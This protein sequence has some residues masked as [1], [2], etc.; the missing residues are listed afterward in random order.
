MSALSSI[1]AQDWQERP[2][3]SSNGDKQGGS[4]EGLHEP[5]RHD[6]RL[7]GQQGQEQQQPHHNHISQQET[8]AAAEEGLRRNQQAVAQNNASSQAGI[9]PTINTTLTHAHPPLPHRSPKHAA[10]SAALHLHLQT[11]VDSL[12]PRGFARL[13]GTPTI[14]ET[15][16]S[17][18]PSLHPSLTS[19]LPIPGA[20]SSI[21]STLSTFSMTSSLSPGSALP[22][23]YLAAMGDLTPLPSPFVGAVPDSPGG[24][25]CVGQPGSPNRSRQSSLLADG[26]SSTGGQPSSLSTSPA[27]PTGKRKKG[28]GSLFHDAA[29]ANATAVQE[30]TQQ[31][32]QPSGTGKGHG[33]NRSI[34]EFVPGA[35]HNIRQRHVTFG[36]GD[37]A[38][39]ETQ[40]Q[41]QREA[42]LA[43]QRGLTVPGG[44]DKQFPTPP[45]STSSVAESDEA[46]ADDEPPFLE[47]GAT[48]EFLEIHCGIH[49]KRR[50][51]RQLRQLGQGTFS[52]VM[53]ATRERVPAHITPEI[54]EK[55]DLHQLVAVKIIEHGPAGGADEQRID[56]S[57]K[58]EVEI[59]KSISHPSLVHLKACEYQSTRALLV[60]TYCPGGDL[61]ELA[62]QQRDLLTPHLVQRMFAELLGAVRYLHAHWIVHRDIKLENVLVNTRDLRAI[63]EPLA[64][65][66]PIITLTDLGL[67]RRIPRAPESAL[68]TTRCGSEDYAAPEILLGQAYDG[69][70]TDAWALG[71]LLYALMEG[72]LPFD[73]AP[74][75]PDRSRNTHRIARCDWIWC[76]FGDEDGEWDD[77]RGQG[78][79]GGREVVEGLLK[80]VRMGRKGLDD[81]AE[82]GWVREGIQ[83]EGGLQ[84]REEDEEEDD[85]SDILI[86]FTDTRGTFDNSLE[87]AHA[88]T[89]ARDRRLTLIIR[90]SH[91]AGEPGMTFEVRYTASFRNPL[92]HFKAACCTTCKPE[93]SVGFK[94]G[95]KEVFES[96]KP[97]KLGRL[98]KSTALLR[99]SST[100]SGFKCAALRSLGFPSKA[101]AS[102][103]PMLPSPSHKQPSSLTTT[104]PTPYKGEPVTLILEDRTHFRMFVKR[105]NVSSLDSVMDAYA[106]Q[107]LR[108]R[109]T[110]RFFYE[111]EKVSRGETPKLVSSSSFL[112]LLLLLLGC[113]GL[114][115]NDI[116]EEYIEQLG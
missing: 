40:Y 112:L 104:G 107:A 28:Y 102:S 115:D 77:A 15:P 44:S 24:L 109:K 55:L 41:M 17:T 63:A 26:P 73:A 81:V 32:T 51:F 30:S 18:E 8:G 87:R 20:G 35:L 95:G 116:I 16:V 89:T 70:Q 79:E 100:V 88:R 6:S 56:T 14:F 1:A 19:P 9:L 47:D 31:S 25:W 12:A 76:R 72:R 75:K 5:Q 105:M 99:V 85:T 114:V 27:S 38:S 29:V 83:V 59:L 50:K 43:T 69:R 61:F 74:G 91:D 53:L 97:S 11:G 96:S 48:C 42:Y 37:A 108:E 36:P 82:M 45:P 67:S 111:G 62:S 93:E 34:S 60:L 7:D 94:L 4:S 64:H 78:F 101:T 66:R 92:A 58:R 54:E 2:R 90:D 57:L 3:A 71:V 106:A 113:L 84:V 65:E 22:S 80:K 86:D 68:L 33:R 98:H 103:S 46:E 13:N 52:K 110:L 23:P 39:L 21:G 10:A 49:H